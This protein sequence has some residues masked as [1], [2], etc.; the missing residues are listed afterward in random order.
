[1]PDI[2]RRTLLRA[3]SVAGAASVGGVAGAGTH[4]LF[5]D[6]ELFGT[7][8]VRAGSLD[9]EIATMTEFGGGTTTTPTQSADTFPAAFVPEP[10]VT[11]EF[12]DI[13]P[14]GGR[15][16]GAV[17]VAARVCDN[18]AYLWLRTDGTDSELAAAIDVEFAY[19]T[20][21]GGE[22]DV[23]YEGSLS[24]LFDAYS[25]GRQ[26]GVSCAELGKVELQGDTFVVESTGDSLPV[27]D[28]PGTLTFNG[29][30]GP[31]D[32]E[33]TAVHWKGGGDE[34]RGVDIA[35]EDVDLCRV[36][37]KGGGGPTSGVVTYPTAC[38]STVTGLLAGDTPS[39][40]PS[41]LSHFVVYECVGDGDCV[42]C[43]PA[44]LTLAWELRNPGAHA[45]ESLAFDLELFARQC[46]YTDSRNP[47]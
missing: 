16:S 20:D 44:C 12:P 32:V 31:V 42:G 33:I 17:T 9:L 40:Q 28:V 2:S 36:D 14:S 47:W 38:A 45:G 18:P 11:V 25:A 22:S 26:L 19:A 34:V 27:D 4:S 35:A 37:V 24:G 13:E 15:A 21:C 5:S 6:R 3:A 23:L 7:N 41:G 10:A 30:D 8:A 39:G 29:S 46:R 43:D 1:M